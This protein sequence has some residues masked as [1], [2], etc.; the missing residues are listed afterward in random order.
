MKYYL[1]D[2]PSGP[3]KSYNTPCIEIKIF[4]LGTRQY[5][6][7]FTNLFTHSHTH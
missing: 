1:K 4:F 7:S 6:Y 2:F 3:L 5:S